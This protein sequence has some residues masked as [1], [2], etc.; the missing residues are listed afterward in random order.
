MQTRSS[1]DLAIVETHPVQYHAPVYRCLEQKFGIRTTAIYGSDFSVAGGFDREFGSKVAWDT[2]LLSGYT[3]VFVSRVRE[4]DCPRP[5]RL[6]AAGVG[7]ALDQAKPKA[8]LLPGYGHRF[9]ITTILLTAHAGIP[10][11]FRGET[12][13]HARSRGPAMAWLRDRLLGSFYRRC[14]ALLYIG[15]RSLSHFR[16]FERDRGGR[17]FY[18]PYCVDTTPFQTG[19]SARAELRP[20]QREQ[21]GIHDKQ[22]VLL[23][24]GKLSRRKGPDLILKAVGQMPDDIRRRLAVVFLGNGEMKESLR[25]LADK[26]G[27]VSRFAG[28]QNQTRLSPFYHAADLLILPSRDSETWG[29]VVNEALHHGLPCVV[30]DAVGCAPDLI[31]PGDT[32]EVATSGCAGSLAAA[33]R[34]AIAL[35]GRLE[36]RESCRRRVMNYSVAD[37]AEGI[38]RAYRHVLEAGA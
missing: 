29:L 14:D 30:S 16:R 9:Y 8:V 36:I 5:E 4:G 15:E 22:F 34:Q 32:G 17:L 11:L 7:R 37:A 20:A 38:A 21:L 2:D 25:D 27:V 23:F 3:S 1:A 18:S 12:T 13:D 33:I 24:S 28:F 10:I 19:E 35:T 31:A 26:V 6:S